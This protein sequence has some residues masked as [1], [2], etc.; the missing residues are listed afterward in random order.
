MLCFHKNVCLVVRVWKH[1]VSDT[2][3]TSML[4]HYKGDNYL[5]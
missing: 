1:V 3:E 2:Q 4:M 5:P